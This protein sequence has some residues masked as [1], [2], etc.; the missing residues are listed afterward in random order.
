MLTGQL[1]LYIGTRDRER[2][3]SALLG[4]EI[5]KLDAEVVRLRALDYERLSNA[6]E[7]ILKTHGPK[8]SAYLIAAGALRPLSSAVATHG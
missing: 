3:Y 6:L 4:Q 1:D 5:A 2:Q 7:K 8:D